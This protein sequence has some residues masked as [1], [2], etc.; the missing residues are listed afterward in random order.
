MSGIFICY[1]REDSAGHV[2]RLRDRLITRFGRRQ[3]F[4]D[5]DSI[6]PGEDFTQAIKDAMTSCDVV[7]VVIGKQWL[8]GFDAKGSSAAV[9]KPTRRLDNPRDFVRQEIAAALTSKRRVIPVLVQGTTMPN[10]E[11]LPENLQGLALHN[12]IEI[13]DGRWDYDVDRLAEAIQKKPLVGRKALVAASIGL[14]VIAFGFATYLI[15]I[16]SNPLSPEHSFFARLPVNPIASELPRSVQPPERSGP[17]QKVGAETAQYPIH[18]RANQEARLITTNHIYKILSAE[19]DRANSST[20]LLRFVVRLTNGGNYDANFWNASFRLLVDGVPRAPISDLNELVAGHS[21][22]EGTVEFTV[23]DKATDV[24]LQLK[25]GGEIADIPID[26][27]ETH[28]QPKPV[29]QTEQQQ[30]NFRNAKFPIRLQA[31]QEVHLTRSDHTYKILSVELDRPNS[32]TLLVRFV[33]RLTNGGNYDAN[34]WNAS[35][36]LLVDGVPRAPISDLN[37]LVAGHSA[38]EGTVE[39]TIPDTTTRIGLQVRGGDEVPEI[40]IDLTPVKL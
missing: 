40:P 30:S 1:R 37:E 13:S 33:I 22:K 20:L 26:L 27:T 38:K 15:F 9:S 6:K 23:P 18:L 7:L 19:L 10:Q 25:V 24:V 4:E 12:A 35:F 31:D 28:S 8:T 5:I 2:G 16:R 14:G 11:D 36:R 39:F 17:K 3:V 29:A 34:F 21:A 32:S